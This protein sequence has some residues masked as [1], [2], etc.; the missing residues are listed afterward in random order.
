MNA[1][2]FYHFFKKEIMVRKKDYNN[3]KNTGKKRKSSKPW[4]CDQ[5][6]KNAAPS[7]QKNPEEFP[8]LYFG[9]NNNFHKFK[10]ALLK[11]ALNEYGNF[12][13]LIKLE[14]YSEP[15]VAQRNP[16][17]YLSAPVNNKMLYQ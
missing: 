3:K 4:R 9:I 12:S 13:N 2:N 7:A 15:Q 14:L 8:I 10:Y 6:E 5:Y 16:F 1:I 17:N 11:D